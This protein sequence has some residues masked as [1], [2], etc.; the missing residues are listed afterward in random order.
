MIVNDEATLK[1]FINLHNNIKKGRS[2]KTAMLVKYY[3]DGCPAC[4]NFQ[5][6][7]NK[8]TRTS[9][10]KHVQFVK[11]NSNIMNSSEGTGFK[12]ILPLNSFLSISSGSLES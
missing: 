2:N 9:P 1:K 7:W 6:E 11:L 10:H 8:A 5:D 4:I 12:K 3:M